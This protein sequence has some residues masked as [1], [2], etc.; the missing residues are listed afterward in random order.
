MTRR[1]LL[2]T[3]AA[4]A[5]GLFACGGDDSARPTAP[6][7]PA[8]PA[9]AVSFA[10]SD[11][12]VREGETLAVKVLYEV[13]ELTAP[14]QVR[15]SAAHDSAS[16]ADYEL[17]ADSV[18]VP[19]GQDLAGDTVIELTA[20]GDFFF[21]EGAETLPL[22]FVPPAGQA[23]LGDP[24]EIA[25]REVG[26][27]PCPGVMLIGLPWSE[28]ESADEDVPNMLA[29]TLS[30]ELRPGSA[31]TRVDLL[32][33]YFD[34]GASGRIAESVSAFGINR[35]GLGSRRAPSS[36]NSTSVGLGRIGSRKK[37]KRAWNWALRAAPVPA[38]RSHPAPAQAAKSFRR[39]GSGPALP[40]SRW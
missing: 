17:S 2:A 32:G 11:L 39:G 9:F 15:L 6:P 10:E 4:A 1:V 19:A 22:S 8:P 5:P 28:E 29:T 7:A 12:E 40:G 26:A 3:A 14:V 13:R 36:T 25:I 33:P 30:I 16:E 37:R 24:V 23:V 34:L 20:L 38:S 21:T 18:W 35:W 27:S 31:G